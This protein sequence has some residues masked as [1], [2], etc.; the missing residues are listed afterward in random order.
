MNVFRHN[1]YQV[2]LMVIGVWCV[3]MEGHADKGWIDLTDQM[4]TNYTFDGN[5]NQG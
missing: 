5:T 1:L 2:F 3:P 4:I